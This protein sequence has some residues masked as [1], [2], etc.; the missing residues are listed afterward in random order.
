GGPMH[1]EELVVEVRIQEAILGP[2]QL[3]PH[4]KGLEAAQEKKDERGDDVTLADRLV[5]N[6]RQP[7]EP[8]GPFRP[9]PRELGALFLFGVRTRLARRRPTPASGAHWRLP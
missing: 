6:A 1:R 4:C 3:K 5:V 9:G 2:R 8:S 7:A